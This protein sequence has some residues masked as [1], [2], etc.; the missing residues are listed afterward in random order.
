MESSHR[1]GDLSVGV[2]AIDQEHR[3]LFAS[4]S[5]LEAAVK[6]HDQRPQAGL[7]LRK[8]ADRA[9]AHFASEE[10]AMT[11]VMYPGLALHGVKHQYLVEQVESLLARCH[12]GGF[13]LNEHSLNFL[14]D[15]L[16]THIQKEDLNFGLWLK[17]HGSR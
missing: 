16:V 1:N 11:A 7:L 14:R 6:I 13:S 5:A 2:D 12:R 9:R 3:E 8:L 4:L 10:A 17:E 15:W